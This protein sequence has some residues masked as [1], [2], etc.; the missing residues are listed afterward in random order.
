[1]NYNFFFTEE[2]TC[3]YLPECI[4]SELGRACHALPW[5]CDSHLTLDNPLW[6]ELDNFTIPEPQ[7][8][9]RE[10]EREREGGRRER[11]NIPFSL[12]LYYL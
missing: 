1:M 5:S 6:K 9:K 2:V 7:V 10:R 8:M 12:G 3:N 4:E 11:A